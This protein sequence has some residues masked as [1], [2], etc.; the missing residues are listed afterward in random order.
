MDYPEGRCADRGEDQI[1]VG[2]LPHTPH[3]S[4]HRRPHNPGAGRIASAFY[5]FSQ[6]QSKRSLRHENNSFG[7]C[8]ERGNH[9]E[10]SFGSG[11]AR[12]AAPRRDCASDAG[13]RRRASSHFFQSLGNPSG[14]VAGPLPCGGYRNCIGPEDG[15]SGACRRRSPD[16]QA[17]LP[18]RTA[19]YDETA[20]MSAKSGKW[21][22]PIDLIRYSTPAKSESVCLGKDC[23]G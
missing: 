18:A 13:P 8:F 6:S 14:N 21:T 11:S 12:P 9:S 7:T 10:R 16:W 22:L 1:A 4:S 20:L 19:E 5:R 23:A 2:G 15:C 3:N 17:C